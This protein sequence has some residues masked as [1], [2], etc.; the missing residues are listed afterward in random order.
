MKQKSPQL[1][2]SSGVDCKISVKWQKINLHLWDEQHK[3]YSTK[4]SLLCSAGL[5]PYKPTMGAM[6]Y[7]AR[8]TLPYYYGPS[9][10]ISFPNYGEPGGLHISRQISKTFIGK[11]WGKHLS[12][13][14]ATAFGVCRNKNLP[15]VLFEQHNALVL[16]TKAE[17]IATEHD[18]KSHGETNKICAL[19]YN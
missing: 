5:A 2:E 10:T 17:I 6:I 1:S 7:S 13:V 11:K 15:S 16:L 4:L 18:Y 19:R 14:Q 8:Q 3:L 9:S 12:T